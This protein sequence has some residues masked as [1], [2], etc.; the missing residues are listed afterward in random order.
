M[1]IW[2]TADHITSTRVLALDAY[3]RARVDGGIAPCRK[4]FDPADLPE[5]L[6]HIVIV[7]FAEKPEDI[8]YRLIGTKVVQISGL[9]FTGMRL[10]DCDFASIDKEIWA[11][12]YRRIGET[13]APIY[14]KAE[15]PIDGEQ[16][17]SV[18]EEFAIFPLSHDGSAIHQ[19]IAIEDYEPLDRLISPDKIRP[20]RVR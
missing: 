11:E 4:R 1:P 12:S 10:G 13:A 2:S 14:G 6:P 8:R 9:D 18:M 7:D 15:I 19:C 16:T 5:L 3:W 20:M 17:I